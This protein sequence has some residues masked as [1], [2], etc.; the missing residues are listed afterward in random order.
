VVFTFW[1]LVMICGWG[2]GA[3]SRVHVSMPLKA[4]GGCVDGMNNLLECAVEQGV[5]ALV[6]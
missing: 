5:L 4:V 2:G 6:V 3:C 1:L